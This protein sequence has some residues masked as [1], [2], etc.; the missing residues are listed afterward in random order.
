MPRFLERQRTRLKPRSYV[1][2]E[3]HLKVH[4]KVLHGSPIEAVTRRAIA[5]RLAEIEKHNGPTA[6]NRVRASLSAYFTWAAKEGYVDANPVA[7]TNKAE[8]KARER[9]LS[10]EEL[11]AIWLAAGDDQFGT[12]VKL[13]M[14]TG[15]RRSE[16]GGLTW[17]EVSPTLPL[18]TLPPTRT[19]NGREHFVPLSE[20]AL[21]IL[22]TQPRRAMGDGTPREYIFGNIVGCGYQNWSRG[23]VD[24]DARIEASHGRALEFRLHDFRRSVSTAL[25]DRFG[26]SPHVVE[27]ILGH[28]GG[29]KGGVAGTYNKAIYLEERR[30]ALDLWGAHIMELVTGKPAKGRVVDLHGRR[31]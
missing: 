6:R 27:E 19:K 7:F 25:H 3:R 20:P 22:R 10:D 2:T 14:L 29:H 23:K 13:L 4:V 15:A 9:V 1:E 12:I 16:I 26:V 17:G 24:L 28:V 31:R 18:I 21:A 8:E 11:R 30:R 5:G